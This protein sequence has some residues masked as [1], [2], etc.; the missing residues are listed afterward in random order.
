M[1]NLGL[2]VISGVV[3]GYLICLC[4]KKIVDQC[5]KK[6][7][8][9]IQPGKGIVYLVGGGP[10]DEEL[11]TLKAQRL[12]S[13]ATVVV[14]DDLVGE[15]IRRMISKECD[16]IYVGKRGGKKDSAKQVDIDNILVKK[17]QEGHQ[18]VRLKGGDPMV[19]GRVHSEIKALS[20]ACCKFEVV[21]G[22]SSVIA[23]PAVANIP[24]T[25]KHLS[26]SFLVISGHKPD[27]MDFPTLSHIDTI[28]LL[29]ATRTISKIVSELVSNGKPKSTPVALIHNGTCPNQ[30]VVYGTLADISEKSSKKS[31]SPAIIVIGEIAKFVNREA[32]LNDE[33]EENVV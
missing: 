21:P 26:K 16:I 9:N 18:V 11:I 12:I 6:K 10:G 4:Q 28:I 14:V 5:E 19:F 1:P 27:E 25:H 30:E 13:S 15:N 17:C 24:I 7:M 32:Y 33:G 23:A 3:C 20:K 31:Y 8:I 22:I 2:S 29:M